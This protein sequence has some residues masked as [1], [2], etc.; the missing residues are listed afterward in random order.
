MRARHIPWIISGPGIH[1]DVDLTVYPK[2]VIDTEDT[3]ATACYLLGIPRQAELV[4]L[5]SPLQP[6]EAD[7]DLAQRSR[8][9]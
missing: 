8:S 5:P 4:D 7:P 3:F 9:A 1:K 6:A 2:T